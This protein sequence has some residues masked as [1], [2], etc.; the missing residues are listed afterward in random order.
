MTTPPTPPFPLTPVTPLTADSGDALLAEGFRCEFHDDAD[1]L[2]G[3]PALNVVA[4]FD[5]V[6][7]SCDFHAKAHLDD[8]FDAASSAWIVERT[9]LGDGHWLAR[10]VELI[11]GTVWFAVD[12]AAGIIVGVGGRREAAELAHWPAEERAILALLPP[13]P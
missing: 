13:N 5:D 6:A 8:E 4:M 1:R 3:D 10:T 2:C 7:L 12:V 11:A 9:P